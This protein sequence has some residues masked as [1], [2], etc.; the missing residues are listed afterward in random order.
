MMFVD[1]I[2]P[3]RLSPLTYKV[4]ADV[5]IDPSDLKG[6]IVR[7]PLMNRRHFGVVV[8]VRETADPSTRGIKE[9]LSVHDAF[10][11]GTFLQF[12]KWLAEYYLT[13]MGLALKSSFFNEAVADMTETK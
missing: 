11:S 13:P 2:F 12:L 9:I 8:D 4:P 5:V 6:R 7:A 3:L 10:A 1:V